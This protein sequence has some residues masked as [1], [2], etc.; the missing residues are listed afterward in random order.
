MASESVKS[1]VDCD[2]DSPQR[3]IA[4]DAKYVTSVELEDI[5]HLAT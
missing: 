2:V 4:S 1:L 5:L 3:A